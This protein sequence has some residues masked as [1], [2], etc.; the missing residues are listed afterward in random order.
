MALD[1]NASQGSS[2][3][4]PST[5]PRARV[6]AREVL[7]DAIAK[8]RTIIGARVS[9]RVV[10]LHTPFDRDAAAAIE[11]IRTTDADG[12]RIIRHSTAHVMADAVQRLFPGTKVTIGPAIDAGFYYD[13]DKPSGPFTDEDLAKIEEAMRGIIAAGKPFRRDVIDREEALDLFGRMGETYKKEIIDAIPE[14]EEI[15]LYRH[16]E[17]AGEWLDVCEGPHVPDTS[18]LGAIKLVSVAGAYWRGDER[19]P[20]LQRIYGTAFPTQQALD[21]HLKLLAEARERDH[22]KLGKE[23]ELFMFHEYAPA[24]PFFLPRGAHVYNAL[25]G[26]MRDLYLDYGYEEVVTPQIFDKRLFETSGHLPNY[27]ENMYLPVTAELLDEARLALRLGVEG[28]ADAASYREADRRRDAAVAQQLMELERLAQKPMNCP[29]H[30]LIFGQRRR[31][32][33]EL[34]WRV[35][36]FGRLHRYE[37]GGVVHGLARVRSFCQDDAHIFCTPDQMQGEIHAFLRLL[38]E[39]FAAFR[40]TK[41]DIK[42]ATRPK[43]RIG[44]EAQWDSAEAALADALRQAKLDFEFAPEE[45]AFYG[46]KL[47]FHVEDAL[48]RSW[49]LGTIQ[50]DYAL[51]DR[52]ELE[53]TG[54]DGGAHRPVMLHRAILGSLERFFSVYVEHVA[55]AFPVWLA[56]EQATIVTVSEKQ[57]A[58]AQEVVSFLRSKRLRVR[59]DT[60]PDKLGA[61]IRAARLTRVPYVVV[62]GDKEAAERKVAPRSRDLNKDLGAMPLEQFAE[63]LIAEAAPPRLAETAAS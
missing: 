47:E 34:P 38:L 18:Y 37:R 3:A 35:A 16:G 9:G 56:P 55:G 43:K 17:G 10:D 4:S 54:A 31:S 36:D 25:V 12:L 24:M 63:R 48:R 61:K 44:T 20:M 33:R 49:Q 7:A 57:A 62:V 14:G 41:I 46:P 51:P 15:S 29:S 26:Y 28:G 58:Y 8:D 22:R 53:Y 52:F 42:L 50:V 39:V 21:E 60:G 23:L 13:F 30:C 5:S 1:P 2:P 11:P 6:T 32:Y 40:F 45:G 27:R 19:N 59:A